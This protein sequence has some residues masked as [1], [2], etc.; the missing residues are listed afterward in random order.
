MTKTELKGKIGQILFYDGCHYKWMFKLFELERIYGP[1]VECLTLFGLDVY[2]E[3]R[4]YS[5]RPQMPFRETL[6]TERIRIPTKKELNLFREKTRKAR[7][8]GKK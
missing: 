5:K 4:F 2:P 1:E 3:I 7:L 8:L 6:Q